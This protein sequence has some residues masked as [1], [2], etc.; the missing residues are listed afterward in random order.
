MKSFDIVI[1]QPAEEDLQDIAD[2]IAKELKEP[3]LAEKFIEKIGN[4][5]LDLEKIPLR[6]ALVSDEKLATQGF[7][8]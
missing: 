4:A 8:N 5:I 6:N 2:Y 3:S 7:R 1:T